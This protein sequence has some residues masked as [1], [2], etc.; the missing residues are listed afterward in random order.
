MSHRRLDGFL[1]RSPR[2]IRSRE[3]PYGGAV[4][5]SGGDFRQISP[6]SM[7]GSRA[8]IVASSINRSP[9]WANMRRRRLARG[10]RLIEGGEESAKY[11]R[12]LGDGS[13]LITARGRLFRAPHR[14]LRGRFRCRIPARRAPARVFPGHRDQVCRWGVS[15]ARRRLGE[16]E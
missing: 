14:Y 9:I 15:F 16:E 4:V 2:D 13:E 8:E 11:M 10:V 7:R 1:D 6:V 3:R 5:V 12:L